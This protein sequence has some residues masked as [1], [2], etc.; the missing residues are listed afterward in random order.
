ME[1]SPTNTYFGQ[2]EAGDV[3]GGKTGSYYVLLPDGKYMT[4]DY[5]ADAQG[6]F[7]KISYHTGGTRPVLG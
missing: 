3:T 1:N 5:R 6:Y 7:P 4:V 2:N